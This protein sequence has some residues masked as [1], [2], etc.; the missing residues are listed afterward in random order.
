MG[1]LTAETVKLIASQIYDY[2]LDD[3]RARAIAGGG[4]PLVTV[5]SR[6]AEALDLRQIEPP[7][8]F[9]NLEAEAARLRRRQA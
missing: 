5:A 4:G 6:L 8:G 9:A 1:T 3:D 2:E 7:F